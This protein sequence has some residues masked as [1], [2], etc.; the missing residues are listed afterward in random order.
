MPVIDALEDINMTDPSL[1]P[2]LAFDERALRSVGGLADLNMSAIDDW[3]EEMFHVEDWSR[4]MWSPE[5]G[6]EHL[7]DQPQDNQ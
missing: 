7:N 6:F 3:T 2:S 1:D 5:T 4:F